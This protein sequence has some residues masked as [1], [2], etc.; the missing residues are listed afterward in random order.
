[1][2]ILAR[3]QCV[4]SILI[5]IL[6]LLYQCSSCQSAFRFLI[7]VCRSLRILIVKSC[8]CLS[9]C[10]KVCFW[11]RNWNT[12]STSAD[13]PA[14]FRTS[15]LS[16]SVSAL[17]TL[18]KSIHSFRV[19]RSTIGHTDPVR[20]VPTEHAPDKWTGRFMHHIPVLFIGQTH[21]LLVSCSCIAIGDLGHLN[22][23]FDYQSMI[24][25]I[26]WAKTP[27]ILCPQLLRCFTSFDC[28]T[29]CWTN[30]KTL[31]WTLRNFRGIFHSF[32]PLN[33]P[34][35]ELIQNK[36]SKLIITFFLSVL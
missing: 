33:R 24:Q 23:G 27:N 12:T 8:V 11:K 16:S 22:H 2:C 13:K 14:S 29:V 36:V 32:R 20:S 10:V 30:L 17:C 28:W 18:E 19:C 15:C 34:N 3:T 5:V 25:V 6:S 35:N 1:M 26:S 21:H 7:S 9:V 4:F 31:P